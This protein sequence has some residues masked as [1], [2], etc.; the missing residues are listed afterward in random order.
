MKKIVTM[1]VALM[2]MVLVNAQNYE[3]LH[4]ADYLNMPEQYFY[5]C[6]TEVYGVIIYGMENCSAKEF[7]LNNEMHFDYCDSIIVTPEYADPNGQ[8]DVYYYGCGNS[9]QM[10]INFVT[11]DIQNPFAEPFLW[12]RT[13]E[14]VELYAP[15]DSVYWSTGEYTNGITV[16]EPGAYSVTITNA[17]G[18][19]TYSIEVHDNV[20]VELATCD[21]ETNLNMVTWPT[22]PA[23]AEY[24][25]QVEV[26]AWSSAPRLTR[27]AT[28]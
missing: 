5:Y 25:S 22:T 3:V 21:L 15:D 4:V 2:S 20:E 17:C 10:Y 9:C 7:I 6:E 28:S 27:T 26:T 1:I 16:T 14:S 11:S 12:K 8:V 13:G 18:S 19:E 24:I 23:Q